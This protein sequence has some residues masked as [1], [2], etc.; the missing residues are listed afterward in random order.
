MKN[1]KSKTLIIC[2]ALA[3]C[4]I[5]GGISAYF[6]DA[7]TTTN[8]FV[9][10]KVSIDLQE[11]DWV[12]P[13]NITPSQEF[14][15][16]PQVKNDG[17]N[18]AFVFVEVVVPY[19]NVVT[20][21][22][23]GTRNLK[24]DTQLFTW[25]VKTGWTQVGTVAKDVNNKTFTY[26]YAYT[27]TDAMTMEAV[28]KGN[29]TPTVF[30]YVRFANVIEDEGLEGVALDVIVNAYAI[31]T[32]NINDGNGALNGDNADGKTAPDAVWSVLKNQN[33]STAVDVTE[34]ANTDIK[35]G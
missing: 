7:D 1:K 17:E 3:L 32:T 10:G 23:D 6:T 24:G 13:T 15:K 21:N 18:D 26:L 27:G 35:Q 16:D 22:E 20:A 19:A 25:D 14:A 28:T 30:D 31:Q 34:A 29:T 2:S 9:V 8:T 12:P 11:P 5:I 4:L 33:P